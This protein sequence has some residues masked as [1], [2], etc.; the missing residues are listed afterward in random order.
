MTRLVHAETKK[1]TTVRSTWWIALAVTAFA[2]LAAVGIL[3]IPGSS[4]M[5]GQAG[6]QTEVL[7]SG[8]PW[9]FAMVLGALLATGEYRHGT[10]IAAVLTTPQ[11]W[12]LLPA[13]AVV[14]AVAGVVLAVLAAAGAGA[15]LGIWLA[16][17]G[18]AFTLGVGEA[19]RMLAGG[20]LFAALMAI[21]GLGVGEV[22][23]SQALALTVLLVA[24]LLVSPLLLAAYPDVG[25]WLPAGL[26]MAML[27]AEGSVATIE[28]FAADPPFGAFGATLVLAAYAAVATVAAAVSLTRR[29]AA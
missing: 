13:K 17:S 16:A 18:E 4:D 1:L 5:L 9:L 23:R 22:L 21:V 3:A 19:A 29:E 20:A 14:A 25:W 6:L 12:P 26:E 10:V 27:P 28:G 8:D 2:T 24:M 7:R 11:R 15:V